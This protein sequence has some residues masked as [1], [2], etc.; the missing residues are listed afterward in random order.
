MIYVQFA[1]ERVGVVFWS[2]D[3]VP[4]SSCK[5]EKQGERKPRHLSRSSNHNIRSSRYKK[6]QSVSL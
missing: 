4:T 5:R 6:G 2:D 1:F 3:Q